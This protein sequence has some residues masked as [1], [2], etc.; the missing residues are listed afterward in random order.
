VDHREGRRNP[1]FTAT[2]ELSLLTVPILP[3]ADTIG[4]VIE[5]ERLILRPLTRDDVNAFVTLHGDA[6]VNRFVGVYSRDQA[7]ERLAGIERQWSERGHGLCAVEMKATGEFIGRCGLNYWQQFDEVEAG[8]TL[9]AE[10]WGQ[11]YATEAAQA[12]ID[13]GFARLDVDYFTAMIRP[14]NT[15]SVRVAKRLG[16]SPRREDTLFGSAVTVYALNRP[17]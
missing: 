16:F 1:V 11:G 8:W 12:C 5:T 2:A 14:G 15:A 6:R 10:A 4:R 7:L 9:K 17:A 3:R 13:W